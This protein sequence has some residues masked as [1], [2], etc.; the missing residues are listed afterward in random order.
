MFCRA[1]KIPLPLQH[2]VK[3]KLETMVRQGILEPV[4]PGGVTNASPVVWQRK[5][6]GALRLCVDI[7]VRINGKVM[8][9]DYPIP[10]TETFFHNLHGASYFGK[11][12][13]SDAYYQTQLDEDAKEICTINTSQGLFKMCRLPQ[14]LKNSSSISQNCIESTLKGIKGVVIFQDDVLVY[15]TT[16]DQYEKRMLAVKSRLRE[17]NFTI[18]EKKSNSKPV[19]SVS[20]LGYSVSKEGIA[21]DPKHV[22]KIKNAKPPSNMKQLVSFFGL[23]NFYGRMIPDFATKKLPLKEIRKDEFRWDK[24]EQNAFE[25]IENELCANPLVQLQLDEGNN[26]DNRRLRE[27]YRRDTLTRRTSCDLHIDEVVTSRKNYSN[28]E[29]EALAIV[30][31]VTS[32][33]QFLLGRRFTLHTDHKPLKYLF[34]PDEE[35]PKTASARITQWAIALMGFDFELMYT[36]GEQIPH[37]D[38][39]SRLD[40]DDDDDNDRVCFALDNIYFVQSELVTQSDTKTE[41]GSNRLFQDVIK[42]IKIGI[43]KQ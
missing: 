1:R 23:A 42:R 20:F 13:L 38:A 6:N 22:E 39:L 3:E 41:L 15:G 34:A 21:P 27:S 32:L 26:R 10:R 7:K 36:P 28:I 25:N 9:E 35:I 8:D 11:I 18:N 33:K 37:A 5:K 17:K 30:F 43:W 2:R 12:D 29:R 31:V 4:Q 16:K 24:E 40:F 14:G 19:S